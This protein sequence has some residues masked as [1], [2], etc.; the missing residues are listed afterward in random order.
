MIADFIFKINRNK[1][2]IFEN[3]LLLRP[4]NLFIT[5]RRNVIIKTLD[6]YAVACQSIHP[7]YGQAVERTASFIARVFY[8]VYS[9]RPFQLVTPPLFN[10]E[11]TR[12]NSQ[13]KQRIS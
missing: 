6:C 11:K 10:I 13:I 9:L 2:Y 8:Q 7:S 5:S 4:P 1:F 3:I 12:E